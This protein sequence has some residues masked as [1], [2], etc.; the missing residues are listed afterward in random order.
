MGSE[1]PLTPSEKEGVGSRKEV[2]QSRSL[3]AEG[4][5]MSESVLVAHCGAREVGRFGGDSSQSSQASWNSVP[6]QSAE[7][8]IRNGLYSH[9]QPC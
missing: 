5:V 3:V 8:P 2:L 6:R 1:F 7:R 9:F 4:N